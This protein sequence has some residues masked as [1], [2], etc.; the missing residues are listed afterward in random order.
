MSFHSLGPRFRLSR[1]LLLFVDNRVHRAASEIVRDEN[2]LTGPHEIPIRGMCY[3]S[4]FAKGPVP[5]S[6][7][8]Q[9]ERVYLQ[10]GEVC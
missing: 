3:V 1:C 2:F 7:C 5:L 10:Y 4:N 6:L 9:R 8:G